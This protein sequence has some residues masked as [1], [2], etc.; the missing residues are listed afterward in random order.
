MS[1]CSS[2]KFICSKSYWKSCELVGDMVQTT[3]EINSNKPLI[4]SDTMLLLLLLLLSSWHYNKEGIHKSLC[5][6]VIQTKKKKN[7]CLPLLNSCRGIELSCSFND[8]FLFL[9]NQAEKMFLFQ[10][11]WRY[12]FPIIWKSDSETT[13]Y[14]F[15]IAWRKE[16]E[17]L[18]LA[19]WS[20][21]FSSSLLTHLPI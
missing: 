2:I 4:I 21:V 5:L 7:T 10:L 6:M 15:S 16:I 12:P 19:L 1:I 8:R 20:L 3:F 18:S 9:K 13:L 11:C 17:F 14:L